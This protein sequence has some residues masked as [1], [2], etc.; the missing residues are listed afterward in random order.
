MLSVTGL[1]HSFTLSVYSDPHRYTGDASDTDGTTTAA[2][3]KIVFILVI[4]YF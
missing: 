4:L 1:A 2:S 3:S